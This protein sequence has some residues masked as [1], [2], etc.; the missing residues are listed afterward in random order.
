MFEEWEKFKGQTIYVSAT[1]GEYELNRT[2]GVFTEQIV[3]PTGL[4][5]PICE[6][7]K[8]FLISQIGSTSPVG[9]TICS[10]KTPFVRFNSYSPGVAET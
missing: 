6:I 1:P 4:V 9:L 3:R 10:V 2:K 7:R 8:A 5:D